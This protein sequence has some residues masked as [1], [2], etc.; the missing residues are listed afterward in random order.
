MS[1]LTY[2]STVVIPAAFGLTAPTAP[3]Q[4]VGIP[5]ACQQGI[6]VILE[7]DMDILQRYIQ[8]L[9]ARAREC[10]SPQEPPK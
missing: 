3:T 6:C 4:Q 5:L 9:E 8:Y 1:M 10:S 2:I 7:Q